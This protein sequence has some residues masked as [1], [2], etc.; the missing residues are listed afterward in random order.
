M[1]EQH[2]SKEGVSKT[3]RAAIW[4]VVTTVALILGIVMMAKLAYMSHES[5]RPGDP[6]MS[7]DAVAQRIAPVAQVAVDPNQPAPAPADATASAP[8]P[9]HAA[10]ADQVAATPAAQPAPDQAASREVPAAQVAAAAT[11]AAAGATVSAAAGGA[12]KGK[13]TYDSICMACH[14]TGA[15]GSP[16]IG[17][18][19]VWGPRIA[20]GKD[21]LY[22]SALKGK[23]LMPAKGGNPTLTDDDVKA[24]VDYIV[25]QSQ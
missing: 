3:I 12:D 16:K 18:K 14:T 5:G 17:D 21:T 2:Y 9:D 7:A 24:A 11:G 4:I 19:A 20:T 15:A 6:G 23:N 25:A 8:T 1:E 13:A 10:P 22:A